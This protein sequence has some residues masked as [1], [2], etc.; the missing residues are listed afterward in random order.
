MKPHYAKVATEFKDRKGIKVGQLDATVHQVIA[1]RYNIKGYP[2]LKY[3]KKDSKDPEDYEGGRTAEDMINF[4]EDRV[5]ADP[6]PLI[7]LTNDKQFQEV[8]S[9]SSLCIISFL[10]SI[11]DCQSACRNEYLDMLKK[12]GEKFKRQRNWSYLWLE[13]ASQLDLE[14]EMEVGGFGYPAMFALNLK[15]QMGTSLKGSFGLNGI[16]EFLRDL[17]YGRIKSGIQLK[18]IPKVSTMEPWDGKDAFLP[19]EEVDDL[20]NDAGQDA[21]DLKEKQEL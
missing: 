11:Y 5:S 7:E 16:S 19:V 14:K 9:G 4:I 6:P 15:K 10:P 8:C 2:T 12:V 3:F 21:D 17:S 13:G 20:D 1:S 18:K